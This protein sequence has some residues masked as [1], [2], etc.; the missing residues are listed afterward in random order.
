M[1]FTTYEK[2]V[3]TAHFYNF[4]VGY[5][6][7]Y[8]GDFTEGIFAALGAPQVIILTTHITQKIIQTN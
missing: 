5:I 4:L 1:R 6:I 3:C 7:L 8:I 2:Q